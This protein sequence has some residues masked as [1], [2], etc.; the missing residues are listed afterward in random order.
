MP[1]AGTQLNPILTVPAHYFVMQTATRADPL[2]A[3]NERAKASGWTFVC[4]PATGFDH[5]A[6]AAALALWRE[7]ARGRAMPSRA[8]MT[9]R[10]MK[11]YLPHM[12][13]L[14]RVGSGKSARYRVRL[15]GTALAS[16]AGDKT[17]Q[18]LEDVV[19]QHLVGSY[20]SVYD[21]VLA[22]LEPV[23]LVRDFQAPEI[24]YLAGESLIAPLALPS[25]GTPLILSITYVARRADR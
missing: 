19:P 15:H 6:L 9:A 22:L 3:F 11:P 8:D 12:S 21:T 1:N 18:F 10:V 2:R 20:S 17:G 23:R 4:G 25:G 16:Y 13:L 14:E 7:K 5:P 24:D